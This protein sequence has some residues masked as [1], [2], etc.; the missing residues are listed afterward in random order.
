[1]KHP[2][3]DISSALNAYADIAAVA[4]SKELASIVE[5]VQQHINMKIQN[6]SAVK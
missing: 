4:H 6:V 3:A 1:M 5:E 2:L